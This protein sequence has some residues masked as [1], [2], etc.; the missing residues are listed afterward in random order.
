MGKDSGGIKEKLDTL[1]DDTQELAK[2]GYK[3]AKLE[4]TEQLSKVVSNTIVISVLLLLF[5]F[6]LLFLFFGLARWIGQ[7]LNDI[8]LGYFIVGGFYL[9]LILLIVAL[10]KSVIVPYFKNMI[11]KKMYE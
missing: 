11:V 9:L 2:T 3:I 4:A 10:R 6:L 1:I 7:E 5:N 8:S